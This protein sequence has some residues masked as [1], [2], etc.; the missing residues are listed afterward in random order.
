MPT[1]I[2]TAAL[3]LAASP[4][5]A[6]VITGPQS[7]VGGPV[8]PAAFGLAIEIVH[9]IIP[10]EQSEKMMQEMMESLLSQM[11]KSLAPEISDPGLEAIFDR[12][13][14][15]IPTRVLPVVRKHMPS[16]ANAMACAY[17]RQFSVAELTEINAFS[18]TPAGKHYFS[19]SVSMIADPSVAAANQAYMADIKPIMQSFQQET[20]DEVI[21]YRNRKK[22]KN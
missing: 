6:Q 1:A 3:A 13:M 15:S 19:R 10:P 8:D 18:K 7:C 11:E 16:I 17:V 12:K 4:A 20:M 5:H 14:K 22:G 9:A 2:A 21:A